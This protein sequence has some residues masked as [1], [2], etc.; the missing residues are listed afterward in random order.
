MKNILSIACAIF[1]LFSLE[2]QAQSSVGL[3]YFGESIINPG[4]KATYE[5]S[6]WSKRKSKPRWLFNRND[7]LGTKVKTQETFVTGNLGFYNVANSHSAILLISEFGYR[8]TKH[9]KGSFLETSLGLGYQ[10]RI[11]NIDTYQLGIGTE[12]DK[13]EAAGQ[14][15]FLTTLS[16]GFGRNLGYRRNI[17]LSWFV[18]PTLML[19]MPQAHTAVPSAALEIG[20]R[21]FI[22]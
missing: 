17:P 10:Q 15:Q 13:L 9:R 2:S 20:L 14:A 11:Y 1:C 3:S 21:Y 7:K 8:R 12:P 6:L 16:F 19:A 22:K 4:M 5:Y 18:K